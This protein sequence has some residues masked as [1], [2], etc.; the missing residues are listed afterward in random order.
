MAS[1]T[2]RGAGLFEAI[3]GLNPH[4]YFPLGS[5]LGAGT[6]EFVNAVTGADIGFDGW[7]GTP[8]HPTDVR[9]GPWTD[10]R[11]VCRSGASWVRDTVTRSFSLGSS[12]T[13]ACFGMTRFAGQTGVIVAWGEQVNDGVMHCVEVLSDTSIRMVIYSGANAIA[14]GVFTVPTADGETREFFTARISNGDTFELHRYNDALDLDAISTTPFLAT[15]DTGTASTIAFFNSTA[16]A[17]QPRA[18]QLDCVLHDV[19]FWD[20]ELTAPEREL[21]ARH[22]A[23]WDS[24]AGRNFKGGSVGGDPD[25]MKW[26][27][28]KMR[29]EMLS[30]Q[31]V[32]DSTTVHK[33]RGWEY[34]IN[35]ALMEAGYPI[36]G[37]GLQ[38]IPG[39]TGTFQ[40]L[41]GVRPLNSADS[42]LGSY[43]G[44]VEVRGTYTAGTGTMQ[45]T[46]ATP[47]GSFGQLALN[48]NSPR[49]LVSAQVLQY[50]EGVFE[51]GV[52]FAVL[53][54]RDDDTLGA[55][56]N[57]SLKRREVGED[58][59]GGN[60]SF[61]G[62]STI[63]LPESGLVD[64]AVTMLAID[65]PAVGPTIQGG[66]DYWVIESG[67]GG[68]A[69][70]SASAGPF[71]MFGQAFH[72]KDALGNLATTGFSVAPMVYYGGNGISTQITE[73][74]LAAPPAAGTK[75]SAWKPI[76]D[77]YKGQLLRGKVESGALP[78]TPLVDDEITN[79]FNAQNA[80][81][82]GSGGVG[83]W[84]D[85]KTGVLTLSQSDSARRP[86][87]NQVTLNGLQIV[88][89]DDDALDFSAAFEHR[90]VLTMLRADGASVDTPTIGFVWGESA[91]SG[92]DYDFIYSTTQGDTDDISVD[93]TVANGITGSASADGATPTAGGN[94][95]VGL[96]AAERAEWRLWFADHTDD[97]GVEHWGARSSSGAGASDFSVGDTG[98]II[99]WRNSPSSL[100]RQRAEGFVAHK[101]NHPLVSGHP[102]ELAAPL[103]TS[104]IG[105]PNFLLWGLS[106]HN[107][108]G[109]AYSTDSVGPNPQPNQGDPDGYKDNW[110][111]LYDAVASIMLHAGVDPEL[112]LRVLIHS[113]HHSEAVGVVADRYQGMEGAVEA[114]ARSVPNSFYIKQEKISPSPYPAEWKDLGTDDVHLSTLGFTENARLMMTAFQKAL[115]SGGRITE[116]TQRFT[117]LTRF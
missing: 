87:L 63:D 57:L 97:V 50:E 20:R 49:N 77:Y 59:D 71:L 108:A 98:D 34:A 37:T 14:F 47:S 73:R 104:N 5:E 86:L 67:V 74:L 113:P 27:D 91:S 46:A 100:S 44:S 41:W 16:G 93:G 76:I 82:N 19:A 62:I 106:N 25:A 53:A 80:V 58:L 26:V 70:Q 102:F 89:F 66:R 54:V 72:F 40:A 31:L 32:G 90:G 11:G 64:E 112:Y 24:S 22:F 75:V 92:S 13:T 29:E 116:R 81:D 3:L 60:R 101:Y 30:I 7:T 115:K 85:E 78:W 79:W 103:A 6:G 109:G 28:A 95:D 84:V 88:S 51:S 36:W 10:S 17:G 96:T 52:E 9:F 105:D 114:I 45:T 61:G 68:V 38:P 39:T 56:G 21:L 69:G 4:D 8:T 35:I 99:I 83:S 48:N 23:A 42:T 111:A 43:A 12:T 15:S 18:G 94:I 65:L 2:G 33:G 110:I 107:E 117:R 55:I 1:L